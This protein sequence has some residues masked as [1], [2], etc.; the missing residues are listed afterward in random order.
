VLASAGVPSRRPR[1]ATSWKESPARAELLALY[2]RADALLAPFSCDSSTECCRFGVTGREPYVTSV[3]LAELQLA[4]AARGGPAPPSARP[5]RSLPVV[6]EERPCPLLDA[7]GRCRVY[8]SRP[9]GCRTFFCE[10]ARGP[11]RLPRTEANAIARDIADLAARVTPRDA[12]SRPLTRA[13]AGVS[14]KKSP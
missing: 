6:S 2:A 11:G 12:G 10:R 4:I 13:L 9:L 8:A 14:E 7:S 3:E 5:L 1:S